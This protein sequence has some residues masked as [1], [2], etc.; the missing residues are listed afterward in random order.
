MHPDGAFLD[1]RRG[2]QAAAIGRNGDAFFFGCTGGELF[3]RAVGKALAPDVKSVSRIG[4]EIHGFAIGAPTRI[5]ATCRV[6]TRGPA[7]RTAVKGNYTA[8]H[9][10]GSIHFRKQNPF[11][12]RRRPGSMR[13]PRGGREVNIAFFGAALVRGYDGHGLGWL[14]EFG[15]QN[16]LVIWPRE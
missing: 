11:A 2:H 8:R 5:R 9:P 4:A 6:W 3:G 16:V 15:K 14:A 13:H 12:V 10:A 1:A 7:G